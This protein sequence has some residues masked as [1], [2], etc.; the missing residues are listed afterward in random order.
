MNIIKYTNVLQFPVNRYVSEPI[1][2]H[3]H[4]SHMATRDWIFI[5]IR[6][7]DAENLEVKYIIFSEYHSSSRVDT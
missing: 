1:A 4:C 5:D 3:M 2:L 6:C 7:I